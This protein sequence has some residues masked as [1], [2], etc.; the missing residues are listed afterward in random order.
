MTVNSVARVRIDSLESV[1]DGVLLK[2]ERGCL[3]VRS[4][5]LD[6]RNVNG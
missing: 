5:V 6:R 2:V 3:R 4:L 1:G